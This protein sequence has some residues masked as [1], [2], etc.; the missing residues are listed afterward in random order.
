M[1]V[2][3]A[4]LVPFRHRQSILP[5]HTG[6]ARLMIDLTRFQTA[7]MTYGKKGQ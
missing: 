7:S 6:F 4:G 2:R 3:R 5:A 1:S